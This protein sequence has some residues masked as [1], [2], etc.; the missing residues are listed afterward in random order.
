[1]GHSKYAARTDANHAEVREALRRAGFV[2]YDTYAAGRGFPDL[3]VS[4]T[5]H[6]PTPASPTARIP[7]TVLLEVKDGAKR[8]G[9]RQLKPDQRKFFRAW[10]GAAAIVYTPE[11][12]VSLCGELS[13]GRF[14]ALASEPYASRRP[15]C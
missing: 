1:M 11:E 9:K 7:Y 13:A 12:A 6:C 4:F 14:G 5:A 3:T 10:A 2:V 15:P 8:D